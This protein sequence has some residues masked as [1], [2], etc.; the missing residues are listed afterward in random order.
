[1][2]SWYEPLLDRSM[3]LYWSAGEPLLVRMRTYIG[4]DVDLYRST[5]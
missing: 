3:N 2:G 5:Q 4:R 1:M